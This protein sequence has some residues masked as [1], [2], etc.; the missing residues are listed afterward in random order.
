MARV[1]MSV[2]FPMQVIGPLELQR[3]LYAM[4]G[5]INGMI[6]RAPVALV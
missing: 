4:A 6:S 3:T 2:D 1:L 5:R